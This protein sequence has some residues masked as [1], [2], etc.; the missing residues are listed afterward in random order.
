M[1]LKVFIHQESFRAVDL[2]I[3]IYASLRSFQLSLNKGALFDLTKFGLLL[4]QI[5]GQLYEYLLRE[6]WSTIES[7]PYFH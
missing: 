7:P 3:S 6:L 4:I 2:V 5:N 1:I